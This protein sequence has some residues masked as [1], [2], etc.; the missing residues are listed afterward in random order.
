[1]QE[2]MEVGLDFHLSGSSDVSVKANQVIF[3]KKKCQTHNIRRVICL[4]VSKILQYNIF[5]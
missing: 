5:A 2:Q 3:G 4:H 1:M